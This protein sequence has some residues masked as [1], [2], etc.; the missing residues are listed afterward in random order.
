[1]IVMVM[2]AVSTNSYRNAV[3]DLRQ[4]PASY[5]W[6]P[7][8]DDVVDEFAMVRRPICSMNPWLRTGGV[9]PAE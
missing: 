4:G 1:M 2:W 9:V 5:Y 6:R 8:L 3:G 7:A